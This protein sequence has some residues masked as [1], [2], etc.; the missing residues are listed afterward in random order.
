MYKHTKC[1][2]KWRKYFIKHAVR[3][4]PRGLGKVLV[5]TDSDTES[6][7]GNLLN[8]EKGREYTSWDVTKFKNHAGW[9]FSTTISLSLCYKICHLHLINLSL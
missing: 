1:G 3:L 6:Q 7:E 2:W 4:S 9:V 5:I 8:V